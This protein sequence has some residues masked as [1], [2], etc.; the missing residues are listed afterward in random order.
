M[1]EKPDSI[2]LVTDDDSLSIKEIIVAWSDAD[3]KLNHLHTFL[4]INRVEGVRVIYN[5]NHKGPGLS[6]RI[7]IQ[8]RGNSTE[9][10]KIVM[11]IRDCLPPEFTMEIPS[12]IQAA[13]KPV[14]M[15]RQLRLEE[16]T[17]G[18]DSHRSK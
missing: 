12:L 17:P 9:A 1:P 10:N 13:R 14:P 18:S 3:F 5:V 8:I 2:D 4:R 7:H 15:R 16:S 6:A 11:S